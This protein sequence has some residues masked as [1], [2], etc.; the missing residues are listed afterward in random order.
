M[1]ILGGLTKAQAVNLRLSTP[2]RERNAILTG[3]GDER[4]AWRGA[5]LNFFR[6]CPHCIADDLVGA[7]P[8]VPLAARAWLRRDWIVDQVRTC[9]V[10]GVRLMES[11][12]T[13]G[14]AVVDFSAIVAGEV[15]PRLSSLRTD[16]VEAV[17]GEFE[18]WVAR[19]LD[20]VREPTNWLDGVP[21]HAAIAT[22]ESLGVQTLGPRRVRIR[23]L[24]D[25]EMATASLAGFRIAAA[26][27]ASIERFLDRLVVRG[28]A[29]GSVGLTNAYGHI[30]AV[31]E[32]DLDD[33]GFQRLR[34]IVRRHAIDNVPLPSGSN[35]LGEVL[36]ERRIHTSASAA[37]ASKTSPST[38]KA[39]FARTGIA[40]T[41]GDPGQPRLTI[42]VDEFEE[43]LREFGAG[44]KVDDVVKALG[45]PKKHLLE[46]VARGHVRT[47]FGSREINK[48][49]HRM[50]RGDLDAF[51]DRL[52]E[53][54]VPVGAPTR[55]QVNLG[56]ACF[57]AST[58]IGDLVGLVLDGRLTWKGYLH[59]SR[60]YEHLL[61]DADEVTR[62][63]QGSGP[64]RHNLT[65]R[66]IY[67]TLPGL[68]REVVEALIRLGQMAVVKEFCPTTRRKLAV[69]TRESFEAFTARYQSITDICQARFLDP[70]VVRRRLAA[71]G[72]VIA[73]DE[74]VT[75]T[76]IY[77]RTQALD[78]ALVGCP[79][80]GTIR[81]TRHH[82][83]SPRSRTRKVIPA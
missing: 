79:L 67:R 29:A 72:C 55:R 3:R 46:L 15:L 33:Q 39:I 35:V 21:L 14:Q 20:G 30:L 77:E 78:A 71:A 42:R 16:A 44:L 32:R 43:R 8:D 27:E 25:Q 81:P 5:H 80:R 19:R 74:T 56:R 2:R 60:R 23:D 64:S 40:P 82:E 59:G 50:A 49:R 52:F 31:V 76:P 10:H 51:M 69:V 48:A 4:L 22:C 73:F 61:V 47:L 57:I 6:F 36:I 54:A 26:G 24:D 70:R 28:H 34:D 17:P 63:L 18:E 45:V 9:H 1:V 75:T 65:K 62:V 83:G 41:A 13:K 38:L 11:S 12:R 68:R 7:P 58:N 53:G 37:A 66:E